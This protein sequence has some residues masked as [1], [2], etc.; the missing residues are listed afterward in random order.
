MVGSGPELAATAGSGI[1]IQYDARDGGDCT[2]LFRL[3][4]D[5]EPNFTYI[6]RVPMFQQDRQS[7][8][9]IYLADAAVYVLAVN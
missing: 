9:G 2:R 8:Q 1:A 7:R 3:V 5:S 6:R 4:P